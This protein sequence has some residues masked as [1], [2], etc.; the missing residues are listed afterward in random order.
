MDVQ[1]FLVKRQALQA[2]L[3]HIRRQMD[4]NK[5][6]LLS[7]IIGL[8]GYL[9]ALQFLLP[10]PGVKKN[11][12]MKILSSAAGLT[13]LGS[14]FKSIKNKVA[15]AVLV[16]GLA[17]ALHA[18]PHPG[19][20]GLGIVAGDPFGPTVKYWMD[21]KHAVDFGVGFDNDITVYGDFLWQAWNH[22]G[23]AREDDIGLYVGLGP[24]FQNQDEDPGDDND[25]TFGI[26]VP[27]GVNYFVK[28]YPIELFAEVVPVF[29]VAPD[30]EVNM[31]AGVGIRFTLW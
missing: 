10:V 17:G 27:F 20:L 24:R 15:A 3:S 4:D 8:V 23:P 18:A 2:R 11:P 14:V 13:S 22:I 19:Q 16:L 21:S 6:S 5:P 7:R 30:T 28:R 12:W 29:Q 1:T 25:D 9:P 31:D 26:R